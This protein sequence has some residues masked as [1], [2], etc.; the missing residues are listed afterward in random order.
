V[1]A[2]A[3]LLVLSAL[4]LALSGLTH[5]GLYDQ[6]AAEYWENGN[7]D[8]LRYS[9]VSVFL[10][11]GTGVGYEDLMRLRQGLAEKY[12][13]DS[14][15]AA[16]E[17]SR[18]W[19]D[20]A[21][22]TGGVT[23]SRGSVSV[24]T[25][26]SGV[27]GDF[28]FFHPEKLMSG[29]YI[30]PD[31]ASKDIVLLDWNTAWRLFGG[32]EIEGM[33]LYVG[34]IPCIVGGVF[35]KSPNDAEEN[36]VY[37]SFELLERINPSVEFSVLEFVLPSPVSGYG[38]ETVEGLLKLAENDRV[39]VENGTRFTRGALLRL[40][41]DFGSSVEQTKSIALPY[42]ENAARRA[43]AKA[44]VYLLLALVFAAFPAVMVITLLVK[45]YRRRGAL[46]PWIKGAPQKLREVKDKIDKRK[47][48]KRDGGD[49]PAPDDFSSELVQ[50]DDGPGGGDDNA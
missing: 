13:A 15:S 31:E 35:E 17:S 12:V 47:N 41:G 22:A 4:M 14:I 9:Q 27:I 40:I 50:G 25:T 32:Y 26:V 23:L 18:L 11:R 34:D 24:Q 30:N 8:S 36:R 38:L 46:A 5:G 16:D 43:E 1:I 49:L 2:A 6:R 39:T 33:G 42:W 45:L 37:V 20:A 21:C 29:Q 7:A 10:G 48:D 3:A 19:I 44:A 28:F